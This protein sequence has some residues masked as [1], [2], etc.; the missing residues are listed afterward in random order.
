MIIWHF[1]KHKNRNSNFAT[2]QCWFT[3]WKVVTVHLIKL[4]RGPKIKSIGKSCAE[5]AAQLFICHDQ[6]ENGDVWFW[7][8]I[9]GLDKEG[10][11]QE[12]LQ[13]PWLWWYSGYSENT[14]WSK[15]LFVNPAEGVHP[16]VLEPW[17]NMKISCHK[18]SK[19]YLSSKTNYIIMKFRSSINAF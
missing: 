1:Y 2:Y 5:R 16:F 6:P 17:H 13:V 3:S 9:L 15:P 11:R 19:C 10:E 4:E 14:V 12:H 7:C 18:A 8:L